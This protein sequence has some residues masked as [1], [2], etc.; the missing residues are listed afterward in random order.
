MEKRDSM[1][2][3][4]LSTA[5]ELVQG[6]R[7]IRGIAE[8]LVIKDGNLFFLSER[9][10]N[11][12]LTPGHGFGLYY[13]DC[14]FLNGYELTIGGR[15][16]EVLV[17]NAERDYMATLGLFNPHLQVDGRDLFKH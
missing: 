4:G 3:E 16:A 7:G 5:Q 6:A 9:D 13:N 8:P 17:R 1:L 15:K 2:V 14:R 12:P 10:R 11:V